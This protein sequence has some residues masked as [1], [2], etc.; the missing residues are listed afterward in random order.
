MLQMVKFEFEKIWSRS[1][2]WIG[3]VIMLIAGLAAS[4]SG[5]G[6]R[7]VTPDGKELRGGEAREY[8]KERTEKYAGPLTNEKAEQILK[9]EKAAEIEDY[10]SYF[11]LPLYN[12]VYQNFGDDYGD[13]YGMTVDEAFTEKGITVEVGYSELWIGMLNSFPIILLG[14][15][16]V[17]VIGVS[18]VFSEE[19]GRKMDALLLTSRH[20][21]KRCVYAKIIASFLF[22]AFSYLAF[23][24]VSFV[25]LLVYNGFYGWDAGVQLD[26]MGVM[27]QVPYTLSC[28]QAVMLMIFGGFLGM[29][30]LTAVTLV[31]SVVSHSSFVAVIIAA[32]LYY[33]PII[34]IQVLDVRILGLTPFGAATNSILLIPKI[35]IAGME[36]LFYAK[37]VLTLFIL[38]VV[39]WITARSVFARHQVK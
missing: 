23:V 25:P 33:L 31:V 16:T 19:Y 2:V 26:E 30:M 29:L 7:V 38:V 4:I 1:I 3:L 13:F 5:N 14:I 36:V 32:L 37:I 6:A 11:S 27:A 9:E 34:F 8:I 18:G 24:V 22:A 35:N 28:G 39:S 21:K 10:A 20:G 15:G 17:A 12:A